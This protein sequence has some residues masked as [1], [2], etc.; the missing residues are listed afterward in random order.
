M[1]EK[2]AREAELAQHIGPVPSPPKAQA[3]PVALPVEAQYKPK[4]TVPEQ[5]RARAG[6]SEGESEA[7]AEA[8]AQAAEADKHASMAIQQNKRYS[9]RKAPPQRQHRTAYLGKVSGSD[10]RRVCL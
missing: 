9:F 10:S 6:S 5:A 8:E 4:P 3:A 2:Q 7:E 1:R